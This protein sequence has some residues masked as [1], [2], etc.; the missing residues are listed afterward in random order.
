MLKKVLLS[1]AMILLVAISYLYFKPNVVKPIAWNAPKDK[2]LSGA[3]KANTV[4]QSVDLLDIGSA[5]GPEDVVID[6]QNW[7]YISVDGGRVLRMR[8]DGTQRSE[9]ASG[10]GRPLGLALDKNDALIIADAYKGIYK[11][12]RS[13]ELHLLVDKVVVD[14]IER[15]LKYANNLAIASNGWIYFTEA[16]DKFGA[17]A[18]GG[19]YPA[20][21]LD[22]MEHGPYGSVFV[23]KPESKLVEQLYKGFHFANGLALSEDEQ[24][25]Y[26]AETGSYRVLELSLSDEPKVEVLVDN[27]P[28]F[29]DNITKGVDGKYWLGL[30]S[31]RN[32]MLDAISDKPKLRHMVQNLPKFLRPKATYYGHV[33]AFDKTGAILYSLQDPEGAYPTNTSV[34]ET[35]EHLFI[36][37]LLAD[38]LARLNWPIE[39][40]QK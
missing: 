25:L 4:L 5:H 12:E 27:L 21:L 38:G 28:A 18:Y 19:S 29:P 6:Q 33:V 9:V 16:S 17:E 37:S 2:G 26:L 1:L 8:K 24:S 15:Q 39:K 3:F 11:L 20:S 34:W 23:Y 40:H 32:A 36:G 7:L 10:L 35:D 22:L 13:G 30:V 14:G 31:P